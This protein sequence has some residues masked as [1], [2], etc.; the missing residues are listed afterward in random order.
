[1]IRRTFAIGTAL[2][3]LAVAQPVTSTLSAQ[4]RPQ[5]GGTFDEQSRFSNEQLDNLVGAIALYPDALLAQVLI[6]AT[7]PD[8]VLDAARWVRA[9]GSRDIDDQSWD[10]SVKS[11]AHYPSA[12][13]L[14]ADREDWMTTLGQAYAN[15]S[16]DVM[17]SVQRMRAMAS[18]QG[19]LESNAQQ[20]VSREDDQYSIAPA[21]P[22][23]IYVPVY[24]PI[25]IYTRPVFRSAF[26]S[27]YWSFGIGF[28]IGSWL[29]YDCDW[30]ERRVYYQGW[31]RAYFGYGGWRA[32]SYPYIRVT[33]IY[34]SPRYRNVYINRDVI[35]RRVEYR[36]VDRYV[37]VHRDTR[38]GR[39][40]GG[41]WDRRDDRRGYDP[42]RIYG[43]TIDRSNGRSG[44]DQN[45]GNDRRDNS[46]DDNRGNNRDTGRDN[47]R[48]NSGYN[49][50]GS[51]GRWSDDG[52]TRGNND[53]GDRTQSGGGYQG[54]DNRGNRM[55]N[56]GANRGGDDRGRRDGGVNDRTQQE[57][58]EQP[59]INPRRVEP[60]AARPAYVPV[61]QEQPRADQPRREP[62]TYDQSRDER[63]RNDRSQYL[64]PRDDRPQS[65]PSR[66]E[67]PQYMEPRND[68]PQYQPPRAEQP[69][70][71]RPQYEQPRPQPPRNEQ[72]MINPRRAEPREERPTGGSDGGNRGGGEGGRGGERGGRGGNGRGEREPVKF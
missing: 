35:R 9:N 70:N 42:R 48:G 66:N 28:P 33:N 57:R 27:R 47:N 43:T 19:N 46:R 44:N 56:D 49:G 3:L 22:R 4:D 50:T 5:Y 29:S 13:N 34:V 14:L 16:G 62:M 61:Q 38:F 25:V 53:R 72:P 60:F 15:Q 69:R 55:P 67:R 54:G 64:V 17:A 41:Y 65:A 68:R 20:L 63:A 26:S 30:R 40:G 12:L 24:D 7:F 58:N 51:T 36:N 23:V 52:G 37:G 1:M 71:D 31:D 32:R 8:Q 45:R 2:S 39:D 59:L 18:S 10:I 6:A 21:Q 11:V